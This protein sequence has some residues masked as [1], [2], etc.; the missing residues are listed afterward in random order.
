MVAAWLPAP[1][2]IGLHTLDE[3]T[4][5]LYAQEIKEALEYIIKNLRKTHDERKAYA[6]R[7]KEIRKLP[8]K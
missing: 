3:E 8:L 7:I 1:S 2:F 5:N 6:A 4:A